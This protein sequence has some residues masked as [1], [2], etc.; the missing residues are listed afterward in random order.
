MLKLGASQ[1]PRPCP[2]SDNCQVVAGNA[3]RT[4][5][6]INGQQQAEARGASLNLGSLGVALPWKGNSGNGGDLQWASVGPGC[7]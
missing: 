1:P 7:P 6:R 3:G 5:G 2:I 4:D